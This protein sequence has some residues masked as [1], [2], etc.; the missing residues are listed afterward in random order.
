MN[1]SGDHGYVPTDP[2][3]FCNRIFVTC[4]MGTE[5]SSEDT[6]TRAK[7]LSSQIGSYHLSI[8]IDTAVKAVLGIFSVATG[9]FPKFSVRGG[10]ARENLALQ[11]VQVILASDWSTL[12][13]T[14]L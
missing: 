3:E 10:S 6:K 13:N 2:Q 8:V 5:N 11:N 9:Q 4:Y 12:I 7:K 14:G 1:I